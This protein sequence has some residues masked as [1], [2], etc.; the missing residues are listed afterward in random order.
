MQ[1]SVC[2]ALKRQLSQESENEAVATLRQRARVT[3]AAAGQSFRDLE[4]EILI[5]RKRRAHIATQ[6]HSHA[7]AAHGEDSDN[8]S[9]IEKAASA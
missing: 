1:C 8:S 7:Q 4:S 9:G 2:A 5:S 6:L 3:A